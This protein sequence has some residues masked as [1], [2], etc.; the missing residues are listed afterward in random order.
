MNADSFRQFYNYHFAESRKLW[1]LCRSLP[2]EQFIRPGSYSHGSV[3]DQVVHLME[4]DEVWFTSLRKE[5]FP[6]PFPPATVDDRAAIRTR[7]DAVEQKMRS[8]L[9]DLSDGMLFERPI[10]E[11]EEDRDLVLWQVLLH[12]ANH[13]TDHRA[14]VL[15][16]LNDLG[17]ETKWQDFIF[18]AYENPA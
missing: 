9:A 16:Q 14:Q 11:P 12:V 1:E 13:G 10:E 8:Y 3:R 17:V 5:E 15:R 6:E 4:A 18:F 7:W 2:Y